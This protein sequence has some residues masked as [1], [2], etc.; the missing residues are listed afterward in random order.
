MVAALFD[1]LKRRIQGWV[2][3][4]FDRQRYDYRKA[5]VEFGRGLEFRDGP[6]RAAG[7]DCGAAAAN[8]AGLAR[9]GVS[10]DRWTDISGWPRGTGCR[11]TLRTSD[12][13]VL[14]WA[15]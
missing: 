1:P 13:S 9:S 3:R 7:V 12:E 15:S 6:E 2:D 5:L 11:A 14:N 8:A 10:A 4:V